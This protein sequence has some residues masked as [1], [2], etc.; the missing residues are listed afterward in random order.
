MN[1]AV[2]NLSLVFTA[3]AL[4]V[5]CSQQ[6]GLLGKWQEIGG[7]ETMQLF[8]DGTVTVLSHGFTL[9]G[10]FSVV[11]GDHIRMEFGVVGKVTG[12]KVA[13]YSVSGDEL[14]M[15]DNEG[16]VSKYRRVQ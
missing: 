10:K 13:R 5:G 9:T 2:R 6:G 14:T 16:S 8:N 3:A 12:P 4:F 7:S 15:T 11:D 1:R